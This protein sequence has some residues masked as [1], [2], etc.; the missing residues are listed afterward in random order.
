MQPNAEA[1]DGY[2][3]ALTTLTANGAVRG[4]RIGLY[5]DGS[6][7]PTVNQAASFGLDVVGI[8]DNADLFRS[9]LEAAFDEYRRAYPTIRVFQIGNEVTTWLPAMSARDYVDKLARIYSHVVNNYPDVTLISE[10]TFGAG[11]IG[12][13]DLSVLV[14]GFVAKGMNRQKLILGLNVYTESALAAYAA[15][16]PTLPGGFRI[17]VTET[18][19]P[20]QTGHV[21]YVNLTY[22]R[23]T[24]LLGAERIYWYA[25]WAGDSGGDSEYSLIKSPV[26]PPIAPGQLFQRLTAPS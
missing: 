22:P 24:A 16:L 12:A 23:L 19:T 13:G 25:L 1:L 11:N 8:M 7:Q 26:R 17:W 10:S 9:D 18:G 3:D 4:V 21:N 14:P 15:I 5:A 2:R 20:D 6:S